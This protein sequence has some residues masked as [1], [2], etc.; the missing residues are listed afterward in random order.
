MELLA[1]NQAGSSFLHPLE[2]AVSKA[3]I[4]MPSGTACT[5]VWSITRLR[6][7]SSHGC[8]QVSFRCSI[9]PAASYI[10]CV[11]SLCQIGSRHAS[12]P[13]AALATEQLL[14]Y[15]C[16][17]DIQAAF[18]I[19][20]ATPDVQFR[21]NIVVKAALSAS[22]SGQTGAAGTYRLGR[23]CRARQQAGLPP[24]VPVSILHT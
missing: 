10:H 17:K 5:P 24:P 1:G 19:L 20:A 21:V 3:A 22:Y 13:Y 12:P 11:L 9:M 16:K 23:W 7:L 4:C 14:G 6:N 8:N 18:G 2:F 15:A